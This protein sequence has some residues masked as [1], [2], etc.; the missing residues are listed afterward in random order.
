[1]FVAPEAE[2]LDP[3]GRVI[4]KHG[5][6]PYW[7]AMD[8]SRITGTVKARA[9]APEAGAIPWLL[10]VTKPNGQQGRFSNVSS[11]QRIHTMG[12]AAPA[13]GCNRGTAGTPA[14]VAYTADYRFFTNVQ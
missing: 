5:A 10:L 8:G 11:V 1:V 12:G 4:G 6:G 9:D 13:G 2:L 14:R 3:Q 7:E